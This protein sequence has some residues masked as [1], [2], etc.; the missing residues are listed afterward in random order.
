MPL[1][2][3]PQKNLKPGK[4]VPLKLDAVTLTLKQKQKIENHKKLFALKKKLKE[5]A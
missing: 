2:T 5:E 1:T 3:F 4:I